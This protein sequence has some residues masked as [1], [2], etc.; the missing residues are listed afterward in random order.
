MR[1]V[2]RERRIE[3]AISIAIVLILEQQLRHPGLN[4][5]LTRVRCEAIDHLFAIAGI[6]IHRQPEIP[7]VAIERIKCDHAFE[8][9]SRNTPTVISPKPQPHP[10]DALRR[11]WIS[12]GKGP[13]GTR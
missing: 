13:G 5:W 9:L 8:T 7:G 4:E 1:R 11:C 10:C 12:S 3:L 6:A 2:S